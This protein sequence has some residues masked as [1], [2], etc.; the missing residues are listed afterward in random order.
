MPNFILVMISSTIT[1]VGA[2]VAL[3]L[4]ARAKKPL[5]KSVTIALALS[6]VIYLDPVIGVGQFGYLIFAFVSIMAAVEPSNSLN[7]KSI[8]KG[9]FVTV[10]VIIVLL[11]ASKFLGF[12]Q[13]IPKYVLGLLYFIT[14]AILW[15]NDKR[16]LKSRSGILLVWSVEA[17]KWCASFPVN[18]YF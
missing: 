17:L 11:A 5:T 7:L 9:F 8:H 16:K 10:G 6:S 15:I 12:S 13:L 18:D 1:I 14:L 3:F 4:A 2:L